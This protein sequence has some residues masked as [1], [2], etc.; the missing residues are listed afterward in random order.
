MDY[1]RVGEPNGKDLI[2]RGWLAGLRPAVGRR[3]IDLGCGAG[4]RAV[5]LPE[6]S[7]DERA[8]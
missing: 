1:D 6:I 5:L 3:A 8:L 4:R 2:A 7:T